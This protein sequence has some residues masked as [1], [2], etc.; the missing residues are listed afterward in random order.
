MG[1][2]YIIAKFLRTDLV[3]CIHS[4]EGKTSSIPVIFPDFGGSS[5][6]GVFFPG[7]T[8]R[9]RNLPTRGFSDVVFL[10]PYSV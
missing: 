6:F 3:I 2:S 1:K 9:R 7:L 4:R 8:L 5:Q 10:R